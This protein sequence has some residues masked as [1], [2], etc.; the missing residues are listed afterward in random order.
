MSSVYLVSYG[1]KGIKSLDQWARLSFCRKTI[2]KNFTVRGYNLKGIYG[3][4]GSGKSALVTSVRILRNLLRSD[5]Y[6]NNLI[7]QRQ[8]EELINKKTGNLEIEVEFLISGQEEK[9]LYQYKVRIEKDLSARYCIAEE[10]L[11]VRNALSHTETFSLVFKSENGE[12]EWIRDEEEEA[13]SRLKDR[14]RNLL[15]RASLSSLMTMNLPLF[16]GKEN[17]NSQ[18]FRDLSYLFY[19]GSSLYVYLEEG[20]DHTD[21]AVDGMMKDT[22]NKEFSRK[23][24]NALLHMEKNSC[25]MLS[26]HNNTVLKHNYPIFKKAVDQLAAFLRIFKAGLQDISIDRRE[27]KDILHCDLILNYQDYSVHAEYE[28]TGVKKL[29]RL[30]SFLNA[31][32]DGGIVF[33]DELDANLHDV[34]LCALLEYLMEYGEGQLCFTTHNIGPMDI[35]RRNKKSIDFLSVDHKIYSWTTNGNYSP[36]KLYKNGMIEGSPFNVDSIDFLGV[37]QPVE[38]EEGES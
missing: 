33:I 27:D 18:V 26:S 34:Y 14:T 19:F 28:S 11:M 7:V 3:A 24:G 2:T 17:V 12:I 38:D 9:R 21:Y 8:M 15:T 31:A 29:I 6:L 4:N 23:V 10:S 5:S 1:V 16:V 35:L 37:F 22:D 20:D 25:F 32:A 30:F 13:V 36:S